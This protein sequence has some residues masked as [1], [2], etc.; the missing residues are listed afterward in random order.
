MKKLLLAL[1]FLYPLTAH[2]E[3]VINTTTG[4]AIVTKS[5]PLLPAFGNACTPTNCTGFYAGAFMAGNGTNADIVGNGLNGSVFAGGGIPGLTV[6]YQF[7]NGTY[8]LGAEASIGYQVNVATTTN[9]VQSNEQGVFAQEG[10][11]VGGNISGLLGQQASITIPNALVNQLISPYAGV[12]AVER[13]FA[14]GWATGAGATFDI[15]P[16]MFIDLRYE[17][18]NYGSA[19]AGALNFNAENL[20]LVGLNYKF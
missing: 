8:F 6:G 3:T 10:I 20:V 7:A 16:R 14:N 1:A 2:A 5:A 12:W 9:G 4:S 17:Y 11:K 13:G 18:I 15:S 19:T